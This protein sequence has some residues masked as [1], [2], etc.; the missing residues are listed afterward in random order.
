MID[1]SDVRNE[2]LSLIDSTEINNE[3]QIKLESLT[4][5]DRENL[6]METFYSEFSKIISWG[7]INSIQY[8]NDFIS[9]NETFQKVLSILVLAKK[10]WI[11]NT[12]IGNIDKI[13]ISF[14]TERLSHTRR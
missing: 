12:I 8:R 1:K 13:I 6:D 11:N 2:I 9:I 3:L 10:L 7:E 14:I 4:I 5:F